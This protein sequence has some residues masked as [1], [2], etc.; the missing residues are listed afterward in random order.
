MDF[1]YLKFCRGSVLT[2][3]NTRLTARHQ[4]RELLL[5]KNCDAA[6][7]NFPPW[8]N[9]VS[10]WAL[11]VRR[12]KPYTSKADEM[13]GTSGSSYC[14]RGK[15]SSPRIPRNALIKLPLNNLCHP[16]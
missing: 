5:G 11:Q 9:K 13:K 10:L 8:S 6:N 14:H 2:W 12:L 3:S 16:S 7:P 15:E 4:A 1:S